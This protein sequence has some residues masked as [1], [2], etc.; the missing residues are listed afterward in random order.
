M[1]VWGPG[2]FWSKHRHHSV[3]LALAL[4][5]NLRVRSG[6]GRSWTRC[7]AAIIKP[8]AFH[9]I[10]GEEVKILLTFVDPESDLAAAL[11]EGIRS[12]ITPVPDSTVA[13]WR[14]YLGDPEKLTSV[15]V[16]PWVRQHLLSNRR[17]PRLH[18]KVRRALQVVREELATARSFALSR[19]AGI[20]GLSKSRFM[21]V[22]TESVGVPL[23]PYILWRRLQMACSEIMNGASIT[24]AAYRAGF[25]D[26]AHLTRTMRQMMGMTPGELARRRPSMRAAFAASA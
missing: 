17:V 1:I 8:D 20:A 12:D 16:E 9:E 26:T 18:P 15:R 10:D 13:V 21:H 4:E 22:F 2:H 19:M 7:G 23:R 25:S 6:P 14:E 24:D 5:G 11:L 3:Q